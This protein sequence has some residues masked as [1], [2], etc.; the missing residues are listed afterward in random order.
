M[1]VLLATPFIENRLQSQ[2]HNIPQLG[3]GYLAASI[4]KSGFDCEVLDAKMLGLS[5]KEVLSRMYSI[6][7]DILG[8]SAMTCEIMRG[9]IM[10]EEAKKI[11]PKVSI[12]VGGC[13]STTLPLETLNE[14]K[15][16][17]FV[18]AGEGEET[19]VELLN[20]LKNDLQGLP[21][22]IKGLAYRDTLGKVIFTGQKE[23]IEDLDNIPPPAWQKFPKTDYYPVITSRG[24]PFGCNFCMHIMGRKIRYRSPLNV[25]GEIEKDIEL[26]NARRIT[27]RDDTFTLENRR[28]E[29]I[30]DLIIK[31]RLNKKIKCD[32]NTN[33]RTVSYDIFK[34]MK[35]AG[36]R[37]IA[38]GVES[39]NEEILKNTGKGVNKNQIQ[40]AVF[41]AKKAGLETTAYYI[42][43]HPDET[44][45]T[46]WDT[47]KF[48][49]KLR[50]KN[51]CI[52]IMVPYPGTE[53]F[54]MAKNGKGG[55]RLIKGSTW[56][57]FDKYL[58]NAL[59]LD[60]IPRSS[61][62]FYQILG[63][64]YFY[65]RNFYILGMFK[66]LLTYLRTIIAILLRWIHRDNAVLEEVST[67]SRKMFHG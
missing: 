18:I 38:F 58:G 66:F 24:C 62:E 48:A 10:A 6:R 37:R 36:F 61:L 51:V 55:Y 9:Q 4:S 43:G 45:K 50:T 14:F 52:G 12:V 46:L 54:D 57:D 34:K 63:Y 15:A 13:H 5:L 44:K 25:V 56:A 31:R 27:F 1:K 41:L 42:L 39:G 8:I 7:P 60:N 29:E 32:A 64:I 67:M 22:N 59:Q 21:F 33:V 30:C 3:I 28:V 2:Y 23:F 40:E 47:I 11:L 16:F 26:F 35:E 17:D 19:F 53:V 65:V 20:S 49:A